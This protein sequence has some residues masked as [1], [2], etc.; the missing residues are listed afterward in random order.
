MSVE[1]LDPPRPAAPP[2]VDARRIAAFDERYGPGAHERLC[3]LLRQPC[4]SFARIAQTFGVTREC[5]RQWHQAWLPD[6]PHG[7]ERRRLCRLRRERRRL[8]DEPLFQSFYRHV[9]PQ[10]A[11]GQLALVPARE[12]FRKRVVRVGGRLVV[13]KRARVYR[14]ARVRETP[15]YALTTYRGSA[16]F[17]YFRLSAS[18]YL[19]L[20]ARLLPGAGTTFLD[21]PMSKYRPFRNTIAALTTSFP[22]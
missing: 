4:M 7:R 12:G 10:L 6:A 18:E 1:L 15:A 8:L 19:L 13:I 9:R 5:V 17:I 22:R 20:P 14:A 11:P 16:E 2:P 3:E 21:T